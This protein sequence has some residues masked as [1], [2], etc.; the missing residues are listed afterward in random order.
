MDGTGVVGWGRPDP[1]PVVGSAG[2]CAALC[3]APGGAP[4][5]PQAQT[6]WEKWVRLLLGK[7]RLPSG[8][9]RPS[10]AAGSPTLPRSP[11]GHQPSDCCPGRGID[12]ALPRQFA[13]NASSSLGGAAQP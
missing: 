6:A 9:K 1:P 11:P 4:R 10:R 13:P 3:P 8:A 5:A 2:R 7:L 12:A